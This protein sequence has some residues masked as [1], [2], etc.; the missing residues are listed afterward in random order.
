MEKRCPHCKSKSV[1]KNGHT[2][3][4]K[5]N[6]YCNK[7]ESQFSDNPENKIIS[8]A[9]KELIK[10]LLLERISLSGICR[11][12]NVSMTWLLNFIK[13]IYHELPNDLN[14]KIKIQSDTILMRVEMDE[15]WSFVGNKENKQWIWLAIDVHTKQIVGF[16][17]GDRSKKSAK[18]LLKHLP[19]EYKNKAQFYTDDY[20]AY[21]G[22]IP[23]KRHTVS[24]KY[25]TH[26]ER[27][28]LTLRQRISRLVRKTLSF[29]KK[30][31]NHIG[32]IKYFI[33]D[34]NLQAAK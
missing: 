18:Q 21:D 17:V 33:C 2:R 3:H 24:K 25:T 4:G 8:D 27:F 32:A 14:I 11:S 15:M 6:H 22:V 31:D 10:K 34:Y 20:A 1:V 28:N 19:P 23:K 12:V 30:L 26:I 16:Y 9:T 29:S 13:T 5:Q 7:C